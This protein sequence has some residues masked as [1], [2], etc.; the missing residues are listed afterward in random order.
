MLIPYSTDMRFGRLP[1]VTL[2]IIVL[3]LLMHYAQQINR[4]E[5][6]QAAT[7]YCRTAQD[8]S[9]LHVVPDD[10]YNSPSCE[11][12]LRGLYRMQ[13][14][15]TGLDGIRTEVRKRNPRISDEE[16]EGAISLIK[17]HYRRFILRVPSSL[18]DKLKFD[19]DN[20]N[21]LQLVTYALAHGDWSHVLGNMI[22]L[23]AFA[24]ALEMAIGSTLVYLGAIL[25]T[26]LG[27]V[28]FYILIGV[29]SGGVNPM[30]GYSGVVMGM[31]GL[32]AY[33]I[34]KARIRALLWFGFFVKRLL[35][36]VW[37]LALWYIGWD[38]FDLIRQGGDL[39]VA[40]SAHIGGG[41]FGYLFGYLWLRQHKVDIAD[42]VADEVEFMRASRADGMG[43]MSSYKGDQ[44]R[45]RAELK[46][47]DDHRALEAWL[48]RIHRD[49][50]NGLEVTASV[51]V[52]VEMDRYGAELESLE[53][54]YKAAQ[55]W[56]GADRFTQRLGRLLIQAYVD[57]NQTGRALKLCADMVKIN[58]KFV[59]GD[60]ETLIPL[61]QA[62]C[63]MQQFDLALALTERALSRYPGFVGALQAE[64][65]ALNI[66]LQDL[67]REAVAKQR[68]LELVGDPA[69]AG[70]IRLQK[71]RPLFE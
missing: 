14:Q 9:E 64:V 59:L 15:E 67:G 69:L 47:V 62:G 10:L 33:L 12:I 4:A 42:A 24:P 32:A 2:T 66:L 43:R 38:L 30:L 60:V 28:A 31:I 54:V 45:I 49:A 41:A 20:F 71:L 1:W 34:P 19:P 21:P 50:T 3:C 58:P 17:D 27:A 7:T 52:V 44:R 56:T 18:D 57:L 53:T 63:D 68:Y 46:A 11:W 61:A 55:T 16:L 36:P 70:N 6:D 13:D 8:L 23:Y 40:Y 39:F 5:I 35:I 25:F 48:L 26:A 65:M 51:R 22:F 29:M 37:M